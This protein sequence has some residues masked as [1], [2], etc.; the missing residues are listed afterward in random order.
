LVQVA[1]VLAA[2][3]EHYDRTASFPADSIAA[4]QDA[5]L[6]TATVH[7]RYGGQGAGLAETAAVLRALGQGDPSAALITAMTR[8]DDGD[9][10]AIAQ[11]PAVKLTGTR[12]A[13]DAVSQAVALIGNNGLTKHNPLERHLRDVLCSRVHTPQDDSIVAA[14]GRAAFPGL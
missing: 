8:V 4:I 10:A 6:L 2:R 3:A 5:G 14:A 12:A 13:I 11:A 7:E 9:A 1:K